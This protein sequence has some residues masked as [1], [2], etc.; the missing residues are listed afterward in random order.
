MEEKDFIVNRSGV[1]YKNL[2]FRIAGIYYH[3][4]QLYF[5]CKVSNSTNIPYEFDNIGFNIQTK[6]RRKT[7][8]ANTEEII[9]IDT[10]Y[11]SA[12]VDNKEITCVFVLKKFT[13]GDDHTLVISIVEKDGGRNM[14]LNITD[15]L[16]LQARNI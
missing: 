1:R 9:P 15:D 8:T 11:E 14:V 5:K 7:T 16:L 10:Y 3:E 2:R 6:K 12:I 13:I 4:D